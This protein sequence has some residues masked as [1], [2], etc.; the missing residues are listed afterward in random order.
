MIIL[1]YVM[2]NSSCSLKHNHQV[3]LVLA[4]LRLCVGNV[5]HKVKHLILWLSASDR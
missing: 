5:M 2:F 4:H 1:R 3:T